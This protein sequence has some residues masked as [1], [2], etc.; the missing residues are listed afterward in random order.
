M[1][2]EK[3]CEIAYSKESNDCLTLYNGSFSE[4]LESV[5]YKILVQQ[6][7]LYRNLSINLEESEI[8]VA[9]YDKRQMNYFDLHEREITHM[10]NKQYEAADSQ[11]RSLFREVKTFDVYDLVIQLVLTIIAILIVF[12]VLLNSSELSLWKAKRMVGILPT[13]YMMEHLQEIE[14]FI[15]KTT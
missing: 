9:K 1:N 10:F 6:Y 11:V 8:R 5:L 12:K 13:K 7:Y 3:L 2:S 4:G 15:K 14:Q